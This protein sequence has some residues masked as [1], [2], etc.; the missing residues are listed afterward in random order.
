MARIGASILVI[1][2]CANTSI[3]QAAP[4]QADY[5]TRA[6]VEAICSITS[7][8]PPMILTATVD[9]NGKLDPTL[10]NTS[11][12]IDGMIC[13]SPSQ[14]VVSATSL[15]LTVPRLVLPTGQSQTINFIAKATG[16]TANPATVTTRDNDRIGSLEVFTGVPQV[17]YNAKA[18][19]I[20]INVQSFSVVTEKAANGKAAPAKPVDGNYAATITISLTP[21]N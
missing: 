14:I 8:L 17:Q 4:G 7:Q 9:K 15:R 18:G 19:A 21:K 3:A 11:F 10:V 6:R 5:Q 13:T 16:W 20:T 12:K 2:A 1:M